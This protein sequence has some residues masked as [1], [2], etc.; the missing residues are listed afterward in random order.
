MALSPTRRLLSATAAFI[1]LLASCG[2]ADDGETAAAKKPDSL[3]EALGFGEE[4]TQAREAKVQEAV[5]R[6]MQKEGFEYVPMDASQMNVHIVGRDGPGGPEDRA[7]RGYGVTTGMDGP[8]VNVPSG[9]NDAN[10]AIR[11]ALSDSDRDA[12]DRALFGAGAHISDDVDEGGGATSGFV[13]VAP[14]AGQ[15]G[16]PGSPDEPENQGCFGRAQS[17]VGGN[18]IDQIGPKLQELQ[19]RI[20][21]DPRMV[22]VNAKWASCMTDAGFSFDSPD[23]IVPHLFGRLQKVLGGG[24]PGGGLVVGPGGLPDSPEMAAL[25]RDELALAKADDA[26]AKKTGRTAVAESVRTETERQFL[27]DN[28]DL[29]ADKAEG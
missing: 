8:T 28:P 29:G 16:E 10:Q 15:T 24:Q 25:Q 23:D 5:R 7:T 13:A 2:R 1:V 21:A 11:E 14:V 22:A 12:Y 9:G 19:E 3:E 17:E 26:C 6:C 18:G 4:A 27:E 20:S